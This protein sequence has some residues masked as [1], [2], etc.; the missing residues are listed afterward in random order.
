M[1]RAKAVRDKQ[2][3]PKERSF[4]EERDVNYRQTPLDLY[5]LI[6]LGSRSLG[7]SSFFGWTRDGAYCQL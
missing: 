1:G 5:E 4:S 7:Y 3:S 2:G 6:Q